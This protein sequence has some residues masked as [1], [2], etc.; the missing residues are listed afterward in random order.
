MTNKIA[1]GW[2][3]G[4]GAETETEGESETEAETEDEGPPP[5]WTISGSHCHLLSGMALPPP[6]PPQIS[7]EGAEGVKRPVSIQVFNPSKERLDLPK[8]MNF[9]P[10]SDFFWKCI[11]FGESKSPLKLNSQFCNP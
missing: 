10:P 3:T 11:H 8:G 6:P 4:R 2:A 7:V 9:R 5:G 1:G